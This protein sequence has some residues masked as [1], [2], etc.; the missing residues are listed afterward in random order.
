[1]Y[2]QSRLKDLPKAIWLRYGA[3]VILNLKG[4]P[5]ELWYLYAATLVSRAGTM[6]LVFLAVY[7]SSLG[8]DPVL[9]G[10]A[11]SVYGL[12]ALIAAPVG[13][14]LCD[15]FNPLLVM[16]VTLYLQGFILL[17]FP[18]AKDFKAFLVITFVWALVGE[19]FRPASSAFIGGLTNEEQ[20]RVSFAFNRTAV[21]VGMTIGPALGGVL[22]H[23]R[24]SYIFIANSTASLTAGAFLTVSLW[25]KKFGDIAVGG[26]KQGGQQNEDPSVLGVRGLLLF[27]LALIP[28]FIVFYQ[29]RSAMPQ[30]FL[31]GGILEPH[32]Y[33]L[34]LPINTL[35]VIVLQTPLS[36]YLEK[37]PEKLCMAVGAFL[38]G[39]GFGCFAFATTFPAV[40]ACVVV[41][42]LGE[43]ALVSSSDSYVSK[44]AGGKKGRYM[45]L[46]HMSLNMAGFIGPGLGSVILSHSALMLWGAAFVWGCVSAVLLLRLT[47]RK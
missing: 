7:L 45:G 46:Y 34:L 30:Y 42:T 20:R 38:V 47:R 19:A 36:I 8:Y 28:A 32:H 27:L 1:V 26:G 22:I 41:W 12:G 13:G 35:M 15:R 37:W 17:M 25:G 24:P 16:K 11:V 6:V 29:Y 43:M 2:L 5:R 3:P 10:L 18:F 40:V 23:T 31:V 9:A 4:L 33:G 21:N 14:Y 44:I 39:T